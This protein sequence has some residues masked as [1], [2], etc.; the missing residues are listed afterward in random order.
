GGIRGKQ[1]RS[2]GP[3][4]P[5][6]RVFV[7]GSRN[8]A[9][10]SDGPTL[11]HRESQRSEFIAGRLWSTRDHTQVVFQCQGG[12]GHRLPYRLQSMVHTEPW[13]HQRDLLS[14]GRSA[15]HAGFSVP[16]QRRGNVLSRG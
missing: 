5:E 7:V 3:W 4:I 1:C 12:A 13:N 10:G 16:D 15:K 9:F 8:L 6:G 11:I 2:W 14:H